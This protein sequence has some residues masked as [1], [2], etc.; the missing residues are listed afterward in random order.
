MMKQIKRRD[1]R[2]TLEE[3]ERKNFVY[4]KFEG[5]LPKDR[6][7]EFMKIFGN[8]GKNIQN[9]IVSTTLEGLWEIDKNE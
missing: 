4:C 2:L 3:K 6:A 9:N 7:L 8:E 5:Q 1:R